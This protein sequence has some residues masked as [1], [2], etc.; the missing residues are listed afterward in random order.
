M[1][2][3]INWDEIH[4]R[5]HLGA[6]SEY[7]VRICQ[8]ANGNP[9]LPE[10]GGTF[11]DAQCETTVKFSKESRMCAGVGVR[12]NPET[13]QVEGFKAALYFY[14]ERTILSIE[15]YEDELR[16]EEFRGKS[17]WK[18]F[19]GYQEKFGETWKDKVK[20]E[21]NKTYRNIQDMIDHIWFESKKAFEGTNRESSFT[22]Q[23]DHLKQMWTPRGIA[24]MVEIGMWEYLFKISGSS[25]ALVSSLYQKGPLV[26]NSPELNR[27]TDA[28]CFADFKRAIN[29]H[30]MLT[31]FYD[32]TDPRRFSMG[33]PA[34]VHRTAERVWQVSPTPERIKYDIEGLP[35]ILDQIIEAQGAAIHYPGSR[36]G[37]RHISLDGKR[38]LKRT[39][40]WTQRK[41][42]TPERRVHPDVRDDTL[43]AD[44]EVEIE[45][46]LDILEE[47]DDAEEDAEAN[48]QD[49]DEEEREDESKEAEE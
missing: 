17:K 43:T 47:V 10:N 34:E 45:D 44:Q 41:N 14:D 49:G 15:K 26:G 18:K 13:N 22:I 42:V 16:L 5:C 40:G 6:S 23:H 38:E 12:R 1:D 20:E 48:D 8:D 2:G 33:T 32:A 28:H 37:G 35:H 3:A 30:T 31:L 4:V 21:V 39:P 36:P 9:C 7:E 46:E 25:C 29:L 27:G 24:Y 11:P 19:S